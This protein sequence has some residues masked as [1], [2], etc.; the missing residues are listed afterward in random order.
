M[1][2]GEIKDEGMSALVYKGFYPGVQV[3]YRI[4]KYNFQQNMTTGIAGGK[5]NNRY[6]GTSLSVK[7]YR[8]NYS[9]LIPVIK[10][11]VFR[12]NAGAV[13]DNYL[14][15]RRHDQY[16]NNKA[17]FEFNSS[18]GL[19]A[20]LCYN[21]GRADDYTGGKFRLITGVSSPLLTAMSRSNDINNRISDFQSPTLKTYI[22]NI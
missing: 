1:S 20:N 19:A 5:L 8:I 17:F 4:D 13:F 12:I 14:A 15:V 7:S 2:N 3:A 11:E 10:T 6:N 21:F 9:G 16:I 18:V 22:K